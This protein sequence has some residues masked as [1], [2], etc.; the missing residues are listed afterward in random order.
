MNSDLSVLAGKYKGRKLQSSLSKLTHPMGS[1]EKNALFN[2]LT[3]Y[4]AGASVLDAY[5]GSGALGVEALSR[6]AKSAT[7]VEKSP[8]ISAIIRQNL[9]T[10]GLECPVFTQDAVKFG[11]NRDFQGS[12]SLVI[13]DPPYDGFRAT[14]IALVANTLQP[15]GILALSYPA[16]VQKPEFPGLK[17]LTAKTY[18]GAGIALYQKATA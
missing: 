6:G 5:A 17:L 2:M 3:P 7:F 11:Q 12:F 14:D 4:L 9:A 15:G 8:R 18:A 1:R 13:A 16:A 10:L